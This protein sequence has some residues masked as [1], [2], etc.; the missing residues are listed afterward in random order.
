MFVTKRSNGTAR[1]YTNAA[2]TENTAS[3]ATIAQRTCITRPTRSILARR[4]SISY[5]VGCSRHDTTAV[6]ASNFAILLCFNHA[7]ERD[8]ARVQ[9][10]SLARVKYGPFAVLQVADQFRDEVGSEVDIL[11]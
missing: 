7:S 3:V 2:T 4:A 1:E 9:G 8:R 11:G 6:R 10:Q 5:W